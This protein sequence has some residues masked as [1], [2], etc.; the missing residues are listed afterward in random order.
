M[1]FLALRN[2]YEVFMTAGFVTPHRMLNMPSPLK[3]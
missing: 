2:T 3:I 1:L